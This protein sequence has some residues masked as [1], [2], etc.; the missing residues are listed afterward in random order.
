MFC[1]SI[2]VMSMSSED[3]KPEVIVGVIYN[4]ILNEM[5]SA[6]RGKGCHINGKLLQ[7]RISENDD[8]AGIKLRESL[9]NV[10]FPVYS[11]ATL[12]VSSK[13]VYTLAT[14]V[15]GLRM[16]ASASQV[17]C[18]VAQ[19]KF[20]AYFS[21]DLNAWDIAAG[22]LIIEESGGYLCN[23]DGTKADITSRDI[24]MT[25]NEG[26]EKHELSEELRLILRENGCHEY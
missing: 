13:A 2:G 6:I 10:G 24:I 25:C 16:I 19:G 17:M 4:P 11:K 22:M 23:F 8:G 5:M 7:S 12:D 14:K 9:V 15:R 1:C 26:N 3:K 18:W 20:N 21:W